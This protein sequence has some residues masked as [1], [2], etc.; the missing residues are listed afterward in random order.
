METPMPAKFE[1]YKDKKGEF[2]FRLKAGNGETILVS[3][4]YKDRSGAQ[5]GIESVKKNSDLLARFEKK[6]STSGKHYFVLK[7]ANHQ[8][9]GTSEM[10]DSESACDGGIKS[11][12]G[13]AKLAGLED[14]TA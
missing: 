4:G 11:V 1:L 14:R 3:E 6:A 13:N 10:Y 5:N 7:A 8:V 9:I 12:I 2:R